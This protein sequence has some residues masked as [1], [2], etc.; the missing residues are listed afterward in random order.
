MNR[1][2]A[3]NSFSGVLGSIFSK[4]FLP[5]VCKGSKI[6]P[7]FWSANGKALKVHILRY[8]GVPP[9]PGD[10]CSCTLQAGGMALLHAVLHLANDKVNLPIDKNFG[11]HV[12]NKPLPLRPLR[13]DMQT[14]SDQETS[15]IRLHVVRTSKRYLNEENLMH[16]R[17]TATISKFSTK[18]FRTY[19]K[20]TEIS[21][22]SVYLCVL[23][24]VL[25]EVQGIS[26]KTR[27]R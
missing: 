12:N 26:M 8:I 24:C 22:L 16:G 6:L 18:N 27:K 14:D 17:Q 25:V 2:T 3:R 21:V 23:F 20:T 7:K 10:P 9:T 11:H 4:N 15:K 1:Y 19:F 5:F 13:F